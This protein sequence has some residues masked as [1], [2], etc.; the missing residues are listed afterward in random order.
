MGRFLCLESSIST[1]QN[2][3]ISLHKLTCKDQSIHNLLQNY[4]NCI[5]NLLKNTKELQ[6][7]I[8][9]LKQI[10]KKSQPSFC[11]FFKQINDNSDP[12]GMEI[13]GET[14][15]QDPL[16]YLR[17]EIEFLIGFLFFHQENYESAYS[18]FNQCMIHHYRYF[19]SISM[20]SLCLFYLVII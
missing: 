16:V 20:T 3:S 1:N 17:N 2:P 13:D 8:K 19:D 5:V 9:E 18:Y 11:K 7:L 15:L 10:L 12:S 4:Y 6:I 14:K